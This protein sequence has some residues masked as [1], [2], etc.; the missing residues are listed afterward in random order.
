MKRHII[1]LIVSILFIPGAIIG[2]IIGMLLGYI[3]YFI[4]DKIMFLNI[5]SFIINSAPILISGIVGGLLSGYICFRIYKN[6]H[7]VSSLIFPFFITIT[8]VVLLLP[9][10]P[11]IALANTLTFLAYF[12]IIKKLLK[13]NEFKT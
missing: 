2:N 12:Y 7:F 8:F 13:E 4:Y 5:P 9:Q 3:F 6:L 1:T 10:K 11:L